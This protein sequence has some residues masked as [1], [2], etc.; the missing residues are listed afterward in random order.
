[1]AADTGL[2]FGQERSKEKPSIWSTN[3]SYL[4]CRTW[5]LM[6]RELPVRWLLKKRLIGSGTKE[7]NVSCMEAAEGNIGENDSDLEKEK[8]ERK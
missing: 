5:P 2:A 1:M 3:M 4:A 7:G 8:N 6:E